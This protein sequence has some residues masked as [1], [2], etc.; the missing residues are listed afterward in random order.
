MAYIAFLFGG[1][2]LRAEQT[3]DE[4][5]S[6]AL[7]SLTRLNTL[8]VSAVNG[9]GGAFASRLPSATSLPMATLPLRPPLLQPL[10]G[11]GGMV[12]KVQQLGLEGM[13]V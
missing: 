7:F 11:L 12:R 1:H 2:R 3:L 10:A 9:A 4:V 6:L 5:L 8:I 13:M